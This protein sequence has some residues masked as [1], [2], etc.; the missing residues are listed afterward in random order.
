MERQ[1]APVWLQP[2]HRWFFFWEDMVPSVSRVVAVAIGAAITSV[3]VVVTTKIKGLVTVPLATVGWI[4]LGVAQEH[5][6][7]VHLGVDGEFLD[8]LRD[9]VDP[10]LARAGFTFNSAFGP[11][12]AR[13]GRSDTFLYEA[14]DP[15]G[16]G[17][18]DVW[19][20]RDRFDGKM[21]VSVDGHR[22]ERLVALRGDPQCATRVTQ[23]EEPVSDVA[24]LVAAF[25]RVLP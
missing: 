8:L 5:D 1:E 15:N 23:A 24:A 9:Q 10:V 22:L 14:A 21:E 18:I 12:R 13:P 19:I 20:R 4:A 11:C 7:R 25:G 17:C 2:V 3:V 6:A 16:N